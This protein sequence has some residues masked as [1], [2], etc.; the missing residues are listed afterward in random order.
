MTV[1]E[2]TIIKL[3]ETDITK[4][5]ARPTHASAENTRKEL[6]KKAAVIKT[7]YDAFPLGTRFGYAAATMLM[8]DYIEKVKKIDSL[9]IDD[10][11]IFKTPIQ[12]EPYD[13]AID[14]VTPDKEI[15]KMEA[16]WTTKKRSIY[17]PRSRG[18]DETLHRQGVRNM[19]ARRNRRRHP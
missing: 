7:R 1:R 3:T 16:A 5:A 2:D 11:W 12:P 8:A 15:P 18:C 13:P 6:T 4:W 19:L 17:L 14:R 9:K 10:T